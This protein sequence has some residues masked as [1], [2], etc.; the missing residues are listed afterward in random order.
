MIPA[1]ITAYPI[2]TVEEGLAEGMNK[3]PGGITW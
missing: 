1:Q 2:Q 3:L